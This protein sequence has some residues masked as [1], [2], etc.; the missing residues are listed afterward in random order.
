MRGEIVNL[1]DDWCCGWP[2]PA[3]PEYAVPV[4]ADRERNVVL[5]RKVLVCTLN[6]VDFDI[7]VA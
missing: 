7:L 1:E 5:A 3:T 2:V 4:C 6:T